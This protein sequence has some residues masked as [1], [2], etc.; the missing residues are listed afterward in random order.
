MKKILF[1]DDD[2]A[3]WGI[4]SRLLIGTA[5]TVVWAETSKDAIRHLSSND[6]DVVLLDH[7][8]GGR[9]FVESGPGTGYE[10]AR[11]LE[12]HP[13]KIPE[14]VIIHSLN[15]DG[16]QNINNV[17]PNAVQIPFLELVRDLHQVL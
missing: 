17:L 5:N 15:P 8:L 14:K 9:I 2:P 3:R 4:F 1:L 13:D 11:W 7:D 16:A 10:V 12:M 6:F